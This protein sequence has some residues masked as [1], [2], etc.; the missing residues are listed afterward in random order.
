MNNNI[1]INPVKATCI[2]YKN[3]LHGIQGLNDT[4]FGICAA[5]SGTNEVYN[6]DPECSKLCKDFIEKRKIEI[7]GVGTCDHQVPYRPV[8]WEQVPRFVP[9]LIKEG[10]SP[11]ESKN[12]CLKLC[13]G[14]FLNEECK[15]K[16]IL[17][18]NSIEIQEP[19]LPVIENLTIKNETSPILKKIILKK[20]ENNY[21][22]LS[23][24]L[25]LIIIF[26][27]LVFVKNKF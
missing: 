7:F 19:S 10:L 8:I 25:I 15:E 16:C 13:E 1:K 12:K 23:I 18:Y 2:K 5:F 4:C 9:K 3:T 6:M 14:A 22:Y 24:V 21:N 11:E 27:I 20:E 26:F 17:D